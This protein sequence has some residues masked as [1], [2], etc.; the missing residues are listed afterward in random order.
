MESGSNAA[1]A[2]RAACL[3]EMAA[4]LAFAMAN[5]DTR[6]AAKFDMRLA[7]NHHDT[8]ATNHV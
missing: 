5:T 6:S 1:G 7:H 8:S 4:V 2:F 3:L